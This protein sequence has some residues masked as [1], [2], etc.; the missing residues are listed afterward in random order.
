MGLLDTLRKE[1]QE[2]KEKK[3]EH[4]TPPPQ[5]HALVEIMQDKNRLHL[6]GELL[7]KGGNVELGAR[8]L[9]GKLKEGDIATL[10]KSRKELSE[11]ITHTEKIEKLLTKDNIIEIG[12]SNPCFQQIINQ[13]TPEGA[14]KVIKSQLMEIA[15]KDE[16]RFKVLASA[17]EAKESHK[18]GEYKKVNDE[19][20]KFLSE[21]NIT[22]EEYRK[23]L[24][25]ED[26]DKKK[27]ALKEL[28]YK[29][30][31]SFKRAINSLSR[32]RWGKD[33]TF[34]ELT[35]SEESLQRASEQLDEASASI[36]A[37]LFMAF[38]Q[39]K[40]MLAAH[41]QELIGGPMP[42][43][44]RTGFKDIKKEADMEEEYLADW[45]NEKK[46]EGF[47]AED[48][49]GQNAIRDGFMGRAKEHY[50]KKNEGKGFWHTV[51][52]SMIESFID[53]KKAELK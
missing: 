23:A 40:D 34:D 33:A 45:E 39:N 21:K 47:D 50:K 36:G 22:Q 31:D 25:I 11:K 1:K 8:L 13:L 17:L 51:I 30:N 9:E 49:A 19:V 15:V 2:A 28:S 53:N 27:Q 35:K 18:N 6:L 29:T 24:A 20:E 38:N 37:Q 5:G 43:E 52:S 10:E 41:S 16:A 46:R 14:I 42:Q 32:G 26:S 7:K 12:L 3:G 4:T 48:E 44:E